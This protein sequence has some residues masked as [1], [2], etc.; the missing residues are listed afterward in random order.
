MPKVSQIHSTPTLSMSPLLRATALGIA[1]LLATSCDEKRA[2]TTIPFLGSTRTV[3]CTYRFVPRGANLAGNGKAAIVV[4]AE[5]P[6][7]KGGLETLLR[8]EGLPPSSRTNRNTYFNFH[9]LDVSGGLATG[10]F[11]VRN[12]QFGP[13]F[14]T[15]L[16]DVTVAVNLQLVP[17]VDR[18][19]ELGFRVKTSHRK[20]SGSGLATFL[21]DWSG[22]RLINVKS[23]I[24]RAFHAAQALM[25]KEIGSGF[26]GEDVSPG[27]GPIRNL[28]L[29]KTR[30][31]TTAT[32]PVA[33]EFIFT[34]G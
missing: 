25:P 21:D 30:F 13:A 7:L 18:R 1:C 17:V 10:S 19:G 23:E 3:N 9:G 27:S 22:G 26:S 31:L 16:S 24:D 32:S 33:L 6:F 20:V 4:V 2:T 15:P 12:Q 11:L 5:L 34:P 14:G 28:T 29:V 8:Q